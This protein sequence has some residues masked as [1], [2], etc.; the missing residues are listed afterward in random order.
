MVTYWT[1]NVRLMRRGLPDRLDFGPADDE[2][3]ESAEQPARRTWAAKVSAVLSMR[4]PVR[5]PGRA[6]AAL[7][8]A[9]ALVAI[10][11]LLPGTGLLLAGRLLAL[12]MVIIFVPLAVVLCDL[13]TTRLPVSWPRFNEAEPGAAPVAP[14]RRPDV[15]GGALLAMLVIAAG[16]GLWQAFL[17]SEPVFVTSD[18]GVYLQYGYWIAVHG[19]ARIPESAAAFGAAP[20]LDFATPGFVASGGSLTPAALPGL[21]L[22]LAGGRWLSGLHGEL[23]MPAVL[24]GCAVLSFGGLVGRLCGGWWAVAG[25]FVLA[26]ALPEVYTSRAPFSEPLVQVLLFGGLCLFTDSLATRRRTLAGLGGLALGL[27]V[28]ASAASL[29]LLLP[30]I[31][32]LAAL[33]TTKRKLAAPFGAGLVVGAGTGLAAGIVLARPYLSALSPQLHLIEL[34][35]YGCCGVA[36]LTLLL[37]MPAV[38]ARVRR[39]CAFHV[40]VVGLRGQQSYLPS[41]GDLAQWLAL[42]LPVAVLVGL[43]ERPYLQ[44]VRGQADPAM[45]RAVAALQ[46]LE[47]LPVDGLRQYYES[48]LHWV[49]WYLGAPALLLA[50]AGVAAIGLRSV[51]AGLGGTPRASAADADADADPGAD[52]D[53]D[54]VAV[55][56]PGPGPVTEPYPAVGPGP[57][58]DPGLRPSPAAGLYGRSDPGPR[59]DPG[60]RPSPAADPD[61]VAIPVAGPAAALDP[62]APAPAAGPPAPTSVVWL[63][64]LPL[65]IVAWSVVTV[66]WDPS[67]VP[68]QP[69]ASHRLVPVVLPGLVLFGVWMS[70]WLLARAWAFGASRTAV[71]AIGACFVLAL[72]APPLITTLNPGLTH[73]P[74][75]SSPTDSSLSSRVSRLISRVQLRGAGASATDGGSAAAAAALCAAIGPSASVLV[76]D[77]S[78]AAT[79]APVIRGMCGQ[80]VALVVPGPSAAASAAALPQAVRAVEQ[81]GRHPVL[82]GP[83]R[84]SVS[85]PGALPRLAF[86]LRTS[87]DAESLTGAPTGTWPVT[88]T[89]WL[90]APGSTGA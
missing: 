33:I 84:S 17:R 89:A 24:G 83:S 46:R 57:R 9:P 1:D 36:A 25:E 32:A 69:M 21:P 54:P 16:F 19:T 38:R 88:Y 68:W 66:L 41:L 43:A 63:W 70:S 82:L 37:A 48:S 6:F 51:E 45:V 44:T 59:P 10:A 3:A 20:R 31:P 2:Q 76:T 79:F 18:P 56:D 78:T 64:G 27:T 22:V 26:A 49:L 13:V 29:G 55:P 4:V 71:A 87:G 23:L 65:L 73:S 75:A 53:A 40:P 86:S 58:P 50:C 67:V 47:G 80:P 15:P 74:S 85:L 34:C 39:V 28:L 81:A 52:A 77:A 14:R 30:A 72:A 62:A 60:L 61:T 5:M 11:W 7:T 90:A 42:V 8:V 12:P 35:A